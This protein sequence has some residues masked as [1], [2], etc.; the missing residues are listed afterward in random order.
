MVQSQPTGWID[1]LVCM[2]KDSLNGC[3]LH[4]YILGVFFLFFFCFCLFFGKSIQYVYSC[5]F[6]LFLFLLARER[7][8]NGEVDG[9]LCIAAHSRLWY[10]CLYIYLY[11]LYVHNLGMHGRFYRLNFKKGNGCLGKQAMEVA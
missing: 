11:V 2:I 6:I 1:G 10:I 7:A 5:L 9:K 4:G 8:L 3:C